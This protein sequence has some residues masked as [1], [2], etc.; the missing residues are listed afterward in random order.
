MRV[1]HRWFRARPPGR[2]PYLLSRLPARTGRLLDVGNI[3]G[4]YG[5]HHHLQDEMDA[6][7]GSV[8]G[9]D[10]DVEASVTAGFS[11][12][13]A[14][15]ATMLPFRDGV[16]DAVYLGEVI[17]H[18]WD[19]RRALSEAARIL[20]AGGWLVLDTPNAFALGRIANWWVRRRDD[21][22]DPDHKV[23]FTPAILAN[24][25]ASVGLEVR[26][27]CTDRK[28]NVGRIR[29]P[30]VPGA[31]RLGSHLLLAAVKRG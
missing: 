24:L 2:Y 29:L 12:Q 10:S 6:R 3:G 21:I 30:W 28:L 16:F 13:V 9:C 15:D 27:M 26:E 11:R 14:G 25:V 4:G 22:G 23:L 1:D 18:L 17:E 20:R 19:P 7:G 31:R 5:S 8:V